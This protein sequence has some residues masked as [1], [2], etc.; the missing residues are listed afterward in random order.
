MQ[1]EKRGLRIEVLTL[2]PEFFASPLTVSIPKRAIDKGV[3]E[4]VT[5]DIRNWG[6]GRHRAVDDTPYGGGPGMVMRPEPVADAVRQARAG[7]PDAPV[8][9]LS[10]QGRRFDQAQAQ[11]LSELPGFVLL[12]GRYEGVDERVIAQ[13]IDEELSVGDFV[14]SGGEPAALVVIDAVARLLPGALG[15]QESA[16]QDSFSDGLLDC[17]HFTRPPEWEG[18]AVPDV[19]LSGDHGA[20]ARWRREQALE[21]TRSRRPDLLT[22]TTAKC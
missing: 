6:V 21:R 7:Y 9:Y 22:E 12:C 20:I 14:L 8:I 17:P 13:E 10:P 3:M 2:F 19:L 4:V 18:L 16:E 5:T 15:S 11:R 1:P